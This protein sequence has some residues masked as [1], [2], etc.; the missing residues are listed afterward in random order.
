ME[1]H[2]AYPNSGTTGYPKAVSVMP[3]KQ[4]DFEC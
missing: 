1:T 4:Y 2:F 3:D